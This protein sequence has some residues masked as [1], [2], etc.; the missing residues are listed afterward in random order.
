MDG[1]EDPNNLPKSSKEAAQD[2]FVALQE[3]LKLFP[4]Y[5]NR[6]FYITG[7]SFAGKEK[8][9]YCLIV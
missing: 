7:E 9:D 4:E 5:K 2:M 3:F 1:M 6:D 8:C